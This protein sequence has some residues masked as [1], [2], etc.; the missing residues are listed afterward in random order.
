[1]S[2]P[3]VN[4]MTQFFAPEAVILR[5]CVWKEKYL[6]KRLFYACK[7]PDENSYLKYVDTGTRYSDYVEYSGYKEKSSGVFSKNGLLSKYQKRELKQ[8]LRETESVIWDFVI[9]FEGEFGKS[10]CESYDTALKMLKQV[11]PQFFKIAGFDFSNITWF[12]GLHTNTDNR[13]IHL[14]FFEKEPMRFKQRHE[15]LQFSEGYIPQTCINVL[16]VMVEQKLTDISAQLRL[17][18]NAYIREASA[19][20]NTEL[21]NERFQ[22]DFRKGLRELAEKLPENGR[23]G[24]DS[25]NMQG[26]KPLIDRL[27]D[28]LVRNTP[29]LLS[30]FNKFSAAITER[31]LKTREMLLRS[32]INKKYWSQYLIADKY[33]TDLYRRTGNKIINSVRVFKAN[34]RKAKSRLARKQIKRDTERKLLDYSLKLQT[35]LEAEAARFFEEYMR[36]YEYARGKE[37]E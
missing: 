1:M 29:A 32:K 27:T 12:A 10:Y 3:N 33:L 34:E 11:L 17:T 4:C 25:A 23:L 24:Y 15:K 13:H 35:D 30:Q 28:E 2:V 18:R 37:L 5:N 21:S 19:A 14:C 6:Q 36:E 9:S 26:L 20:I 22:T 8:K 7:Q 31:D 16:K